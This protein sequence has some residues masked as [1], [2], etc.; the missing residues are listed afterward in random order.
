MLPSCSCVTSTFAILKVCQQ[1]QFKTEKDEDEE[2]NYRYQPVPQNYLFETG[3]FYSY[4]YL[5]QVNQLL[6][7]SVQSRLRNSSLSMECFSWLKSCLGQSSCENFAR[8]CLLALA[9]ATPGLEKVSVT[10]ERDCCGFCSKRYFK[11]EG[12]CLQLSL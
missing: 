11:I 1:R 6:L 2:M 10:E 5:D 7:L 8:F 3:N 9:V 12:V 4:F